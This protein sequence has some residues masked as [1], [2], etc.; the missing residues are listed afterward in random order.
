M[1]RLDVDA[2]LRK[3]ILFSV[4]R[5]LTDWVGPRSHK[6]GE[7]VCPIPFF[8]L[9]S[10]VLAS[11]SRLLAGKARSLVCNPHS[12]LRLLHLLIAKPSLLLSRLVGSLQLHPLDEALKLAVAAA[13]DLCGGC[14]V[15]LGQLLQ[16]F[17]LLHASLLD[18]VAVE[19]LLESLLIALSLGDG[20][21]YGGSE[22][23]WCLH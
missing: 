20:S 18:L 2:I 9:P 6:A 8:L 5:R 16:A 7:N 19:E 1:R 14:P 11:E 17:Y 10:P 4:N 13:L 3:D 21:G 22:S 15:A 12:L 23:Y